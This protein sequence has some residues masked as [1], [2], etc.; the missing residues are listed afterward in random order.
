M[1]CYD[2]AM[3]GSTQLTTGDQAKA[4][5]LKM[6]VYFCVAFLVIGGLYGFRCWKAGTVLRPVLSPEPHWHECWEED[7]NSN[8]I[9]HALWRDEMARATRETDTLSDDW[10][11]GIVVHG[12]H[13]CM[14]SIDTKV[15]TIKW[16]RDPPNGVYFSVPNLTDTKAQ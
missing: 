9:C 16:S 4:R 12:T 8:F 1:V 15:W 2:Q 5:A 13:V 6:A 14:L 3:N 7:E 11:D 10:S